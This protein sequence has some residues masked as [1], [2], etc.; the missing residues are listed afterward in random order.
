[1][2]PEDIPVGG[3]THINFAFL[4]I[5]PKSFEIVPMKDDQQGLYSRVVALK[6][7]KPELKVWISIGGWDFNDPGATATTF[8]D[9]AESSSNQMA[10]FGSLLSF[11]EK[12]GFD[13]VDLD[14]YDISFRSLESKCEY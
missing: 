4:Y 11:L 9:L 12:Y 8:S 13:G 2:Q 1:M 3:Y 10:F 6:K 14:W 5:D 7:R